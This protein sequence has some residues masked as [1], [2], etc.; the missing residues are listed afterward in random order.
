MG[1]GK[2]LYIVA[3][4]VMTYGMLWSILGPFIARRFEARTRTEL[5]TIVAN[6]AAIGETSP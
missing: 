4:V 6:A 5:D 1:P 2:W 3:G